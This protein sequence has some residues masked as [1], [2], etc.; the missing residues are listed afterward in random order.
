MA[1]VNRM[2]DQPLAV[3]DGLLPETLVGAQVRGGV[4]LGSMKFNYAA[5]AANAPSLNTDTNGGSAL[6]T[7][8]FDNF[9]NGNGN[10]VGG[11][12]L[13]FLPIPELEQGYGLIYGGVGSA[14]TPA[15]AFLQSADLNFVKDSAA[16]RGSLRLSAQ[17]VWSAVD[18]VDYGAA[19]SFDNKRDGGYSQI[20]Y[21]PTKWGSPVLARFE[22]VFRF[23]ILN[24]KNTPAAYDEWRYTLG[25][26]YWFGAMTVAKIGYEFD[27][28]DGDTAHNAVMV[29]FATGF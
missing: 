17:W 24:Q 28:R 4:P 16:L 10:F 19:G 23:D 9:D 12:H 29:Q 25:L 2:A 15:N 13:G 20:S 26:N 22:P 5:F 6:G 14:E 1:W 27:Q 21:R 3:Y 8:A 11:G 7:L 18:H